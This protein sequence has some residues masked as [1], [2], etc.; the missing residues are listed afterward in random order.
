MKYPSESAVQNHYLE[1][2]LPHPPF[3]EPRQFLKN[4]EFYKPER[5][6]WNNPHRA[7]D[8]MYKFYHA[9]NDQYTRLKEPL[10]KRQEERD[11]EEAE[12]KRIH[13]LI[14]FRNKAREEFLEKQKQREVME[15]R[16][17]NDS[18]PNTCEV[19]TDTALNTE[20]K[21]KSQSTIHHATKANSRRQQ[22][23]QSERMIKIEDSYKAGM[24]KYDQKV[25]EIGRLIS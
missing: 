13:R 15:S 2:I 14:A 20:V 21:Y 23:Q 17:R 4:R 22:Q 24:R 9:Y 25:Q 7:S 3:P 11:R 19:R 16:L 10:L 8:Q 1:A 12:T 5:F 18:L 6:I